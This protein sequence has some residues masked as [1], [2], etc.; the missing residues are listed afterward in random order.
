ML[1]LGAGA[2]LPGIVCCVLGAQRVRL[3]S[4]IPTSVWNVSCDGLVVCGFCCGTE[5][6]TDMDSHR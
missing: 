4:L 2:G 3:L 1:E 5:C 6:H